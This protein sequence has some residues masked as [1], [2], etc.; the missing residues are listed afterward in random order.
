MDWF[1]R[2]KPA[3]LIEQC[4]ADWEAMRPEVTDVWQ[5]VKDHMDDTTVLNA[6]GKPALELKMETLW[7]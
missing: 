4:V 7:Y 3:D 6:N 2:K 5:Q 1:W